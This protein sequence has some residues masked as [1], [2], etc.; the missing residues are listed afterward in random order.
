MKPIPLVAPGLAAVR[1]RPTTKVFG[2]RQSHIRT[3][4]RSLRSRLRS[5]ARRRERFGEDRGYAL[6]AVH[7]NSGGVSLVEALEIVD[8]IGGLVAEIAREAA[9]RDGHEVRAAHN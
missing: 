5:D 9:I 2:F 1:S 8:L 3:G 7:H 4:R 6:R